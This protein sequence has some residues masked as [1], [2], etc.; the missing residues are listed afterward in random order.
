[1]SGKKPVNPAKPYTWREVLA[2]ICKSEEA[3]ESWQEIAQTRSSE[4]VSALERTLVSLA[5]VPYTLAKVKTYDW[6]AKNKRLARIPARLERA[7]LDVEFACRH[8]TVWIPTAK[9]L[10]GDTAKVVREFQDGF[11]G[12]SAHLRFLANE[13]RR[14]M[15]RHKHTKV[16][17]KNEAA[18]KVRL[19]LFGLEATGSLDLQEASDILQPIYSAIGLTSPTM[20]EAL[21]NVESLQALLRRRAHPF[22]FTES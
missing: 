20:G 19:F 14:L 11:F 12:T 22:P 13:I 15:R 7:A 3:Q 21:P 16:R 9:G 8:P 10:N 6:P 4:T 1:M 18:N 17:L 2:L 5:N